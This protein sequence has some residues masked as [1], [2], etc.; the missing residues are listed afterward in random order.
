MVPEALSALLNAGEQPVCV[1]S[2]DD[3]ARERLAG[4][5][6][7]V[8][9]SSAVT[10]AAV[11]S[12][13]AVASDTTPAGV[14]YVSPEHGE[15]HPWDETNTTGTESRADA[16][17]RGPA[18]LAGAI[19]DD[20]VPVVVVG[21]T[22]DVAAAYEAGVTEVIPLSVSEHAE[23]IA[24]RVAATVARYRR[25]ELTGDLLDEVNDGIVLHDPE[26]GEVVRA[27]D[28]LYEM[29]GYDPE[30][31]DIRLDDIAGHDD[32]FTVERAVSL[33]RDAAE[34]SPSTFEW[35]DPTSD[36]SGLWVE[37]T[38]ESAS[39]AGEQYVVSSVR[40]VDA[41][42]RRERE[43]EASRERLERLR[44]ITSDPDREFE[45][46]VQALFEFGASQLGLD[47]AFLGHVDEDDGTFRI[48]HAYG[49]HPALEAGAESALA[50]SYCRWTLDP[51]IGSPLAVDTAAEDETISSRAYE[52]WGLECYLGAKITV[53]GSPY[54]T[55][56]FADDEPRHRP[57]SD[58]E[59][60]LIEYMS[61]WL[62][63][64]LE[65]RA[66][67][68][69][70][71]ATRRRLDDTLERVQD[72]FFAVD[73]G[74]HVRYV[75]ETGAEVLRR[76]MAKPYD[77]EELL[78]K[79][80]WEEIPDAVETPLYDR[81]RTAMREQEPVTFEERY[82]PLDAW[83]EVRAYP[84]ESG[85]S[86]YFS[87]VTERKE[88]EQELYILERAMEEAS[89][90]LTL[91]D[92]DAEGEPLVFVNEAF[93][94][95]TGYD[96]SEAVGRNC[97]FLQGP[98]TDPDAVAEIREAIDDEETLS[99]ELRNY[100]ADGTPFW[101]R[102]ELAPIYDEDGSLL[103]YLGSQYDVTEDHRNREVRRQL[104][105]TTRDLVD[106]SSRAEIASLVS[107]SAADILDHDVNAVYLCSDEAGADRLEPVAVSD[108]A[109]DLLDDLPSTSGDDLLQRALDRDDA[110]RID[111]VSE[112]EGV[113]ESPLVPLRSLLLLPIEDAGVLVS[114]SADRASFDDAEVDRAQLLTTSA[115]RALARTE[116]RA[117]LKRYETVFETVQDKLYVADEDGHIEMVSEPLA[118]AVGASQE[119]LVGEHV[120][121]VVTE[122]TV[123][124]GQE[125]VFDLL[126]APEAA[127]STYE[128]ALR[129]D[130]GTETPVEIEISVLPYENE[131]GGTVGAVRD[132]SE[133]RRREEELDVFQRAIDEA[134]VGLAM[135]DG[136]G[137]FEYVNEHYAQMLGMSREALETTPVWEV[138][139]ELD[140]A[141][142]DGFWASFIAGETRSTETTHRRADGSAVPVETVTTAVEIDGV[143]HHFVTV[144]EI[145]SRRERR[146]QSEVLHRILRHNLRN[147]LTVVLGHAE[148]LRTRRDGDVADAATTILETTEDLLSLT[149]AAKDAARL[150]GRDTVRK[151]VNV[152][153]ML[154]EEVRSLESAPELVVRTDLPDQQYV[155]A[156][157]PLRMAFSQLLT[158]AVEHNDAASPRLCVG[159]ATATDDTGWCTI[160][161][162][163]NGP[164]IPENELEVL[165]AGEVTPLKHGTGMG[166]WVAHWAVTRYG[167]ELAFEESAAGGNKVC[168]KLPV[169]DEPDGDDAP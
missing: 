30:T 38:L 17:R 166:L 109:V 61:Q 143:R 12:M 47:I 48:A 49:D 57:F 121:T 131:F 103:R 33:V 153:E 24:E 60:S 64:E 2:T 80:L 145:T 100:T 18:T 167:G 108:P 55:L 168:I 72:G 147:D 31:D 32:E 8:E 69:E 138:I 119:E 77:A 62:Q 84:D 89:L 132:I 83:F 94:V 45:A 19:D 135:Y 96:A 91:A 1:V 86:V 158:N 139:E 112:H 73:N 161:I 95:L 36:G 28:R 117:E 41:R 123:D 67:L 128:G 114:G 148:R 142:F 43:L 137:R 9:R 59:R 92:P 70:V 42:K 4:R 144:N 74:W 50:E 52:R 23:T 27:N 78:G 159:I 20:R 130:T 160:E 150:L 7:T 82:E 35:K 5:L 63:Q 39:L 6:S 156:G 162:A 3:S 68:E 65:R 11:D 111:D 136:E 124:R 101:N 21:S 169:A 54:G 106:A 51:D 113:P 14:V 88:R 90:P 102:L 29:L 25:S 152:V 126:V 122:E 115:G 85:L 44:E 37:V 155:L 66:Y 165:A 164:G 120:S 97:R 116:R 26:T 56:C 16:E 154:R 58:A 15:K 40:N 10:V 98:D 81:F 146:Q 79:H 118:N 46:Q 71:E 22:V 13:T 104:L 140:A 157:T 105:S 110:L 75:N 141:T 107:D 87:D 133:R 125:V 149:E 134:G 129:D 163:D 76:A 151:P 53:N 127:S 34:G 99:T 93:E